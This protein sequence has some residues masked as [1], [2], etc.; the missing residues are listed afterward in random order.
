MTDQ[1]LQYSNMLGRWSFAHQ[2][3]VGIQQGIVS[4]FTLQGLDAADSRRWTVHL[5]HFKFS[6]PPGFAL[7]P[8]VS[9]DNQVDSEADFRV[10]IDYGVDGAEETV[11]VDW[12]CQGCTFDLHAGSF[13]IGLIARNS[14]VAPAPLLGGF[15]V[16]AGSGARSPMNSP[17]LTDAIL[18]VG[19]LAL[20]AFPRPP[21]AIAYRVWL[22]TG[23]GGPVFLEESTDNTGTVIKTDGSFALT[24]TTAALYEWSNQAAWIPL[25]QRAQFVLV[26]NTSITDG[27]SFSIEWLLDLG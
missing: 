12:P 9:P 23:L 16:P 19:A 5:N 6:G 27:I 13:R 1:V 2:S 17:V 24:T 21:R 26:T 14:I 11:F 10:R 22:T 3:I 18:N 4:L 25:H 15:V 7:N 8:N 20:A